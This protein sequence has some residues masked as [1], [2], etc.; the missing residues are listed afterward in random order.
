M[1]LLGLTMG[2]ISTAEIGTRHWT[3]LQGAAAG[4]VAEESPHGNQQCLI[5]VGRDHNGELDGADWHFE[6]PT[7]LYLDSWIF[8]H[9]APYRVGFENYRMHMEAVL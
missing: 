9:T 2:N 7:V 5:Q 3:G 8:P 6:G 4:V 1:G